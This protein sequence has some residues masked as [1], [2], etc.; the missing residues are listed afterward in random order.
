M[1]PPCYNLPGF[2]TKKLIGNT[3]LLP[4]NLF[5]LR[6]LY[7]L[8]QEGAPGRIFTSSTTPRFNW[9]NIY[10]DLDAVPIEKGDEDENGEPVFTVQL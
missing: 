5:L 4:E 2:F 3:T 10:Y 6:L 1:K 9:F 7:K 8:K